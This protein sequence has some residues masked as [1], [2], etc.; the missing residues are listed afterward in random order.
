MNKK[1]SDTAGDNFLAAIIA[2]QTKTLQRQNEAIDELL[3]SKNIESLYEHIEITNE[4][5][6]NIEK[7]LSNRACI[8]LPNFKEELK[9]R[10]QMIAEAAEQVYNN[11]A[12]VKYLQDRG[13]PRYEDWRERKSEI[14][15]PEIL[16]DV[17]DYEEYLKQS[18][19]EVKN[20]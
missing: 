8:G 4:Q 9:S 10:N 11:L 2:Q 17:A 5:A 20:A 3:K 7:D 1:D 6:T 16:K 12:Q 13:F 19:K 18:N 15:N 14:K